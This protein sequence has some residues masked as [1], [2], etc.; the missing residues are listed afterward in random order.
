MVQKEKVALFPELYKRVP[1]SEF[2]CYVGTYI[3]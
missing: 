1:V 3:A 2:F